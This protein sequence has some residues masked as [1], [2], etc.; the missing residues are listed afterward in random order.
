M[1]LSSFLSTLS[2][3][4]IQIIRYRQNSCF[5]KKN[6][7]LFVLPTCSLGYL[8]REIHKYA[9]KYL[10]TKVAVSFYCAVKPPYSMKIRLS[11]AT[12]DVRNLSILFTLNTSFLFVVVDIDYCCVFIVVFVR[13]PYW[14]DQHH[15]TTKKAS[16]G[17]KRII[18][19]HIPMVVPSEGELLSVRGFG[20]KLFNPRKCVVTMRQRTVRYSCTYQIVITS[21][22]HEGR[23]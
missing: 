7:L 1:V 10:H 8:L 14:R 6:Y 17:I 2:P 11:P 20:D 12:K 3:S 18:F 21:F 22:W 13:R 5:T 19:R 4:F 16:C 9:I 15:P 23:K